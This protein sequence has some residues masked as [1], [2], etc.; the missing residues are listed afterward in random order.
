ME[1][2]YE[3]IVFIVCLVLTFVITFAAFKSI[4]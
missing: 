3:L 2:H 1:Q 4:P